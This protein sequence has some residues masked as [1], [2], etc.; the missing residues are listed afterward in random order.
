V[1]I[2]S[3]AAIPKAA[4]PGAATKPSDKSAQ[5]KEGGKGGEGKPGESKGGEGKAQSK[6]GGQPGQSGEPSQAK[7]GDQKNQPPPDGAESPQQ[8]ARKKVKDAEEHAGK[9]T[10]K[11]GEDKRREAV[12][13]QEE[14]VRNLE[15]AKKKLEDLLRQLREE[16]LERLLEALKSRCEK[17]LAMQLR[18]LDGTVA[19][20]RAIDN[21]PD[22]KAKREN[23]QDSLNL[24]DEEKKIVHEAT[25]AIEMLEA[26]GSAVAFPEVFH[27]VRDDM[28]NVERRLGAV[29]VGKVTQA[30]EQD[31]CDTL[32][33]MIK[34]LEQAKKELQDKKSPPPKP[35]PQGPP[36]DP[37]LIDKIAE[38]KMIRSMQ[39]RVNGRTELYGKQYEGE[40][41]QTQ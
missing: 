29:D 4:R 38:L 27:Q 20:A 14:V 9:A 17:M 13:D 36:P 40:Q 8:E 15:K 32:K 18:V 28:K 19:V 41:A 30:V 24:S 23:L 7:G 21:Y 25:K 39:I 37:K 2:R 31:I 5:S 3:P 12:E 11:I 33:E 22:K 26:E 6:S 10:E 16:E 1:A 35:G 34:A